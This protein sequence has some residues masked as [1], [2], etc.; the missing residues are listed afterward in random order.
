MRYAIISSLPAARQASIICR[1]PAC[2]V[3]IGFPHKTCL[4]AFAPRTV[5]SAC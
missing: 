1:H 2:D 4:P 3:A 5:N